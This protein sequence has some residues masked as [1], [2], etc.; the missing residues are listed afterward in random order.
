MACAQIDVDVDFRALE[1]SQRLV[2]VEGHCKALPTY[3]NA[4]DVYTDRTLIELGAR[5]PERGGN[6]APIGV[7]AVDRRFHERRIRHRSRSPV[8]I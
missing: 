5:P 6:P 1:S 2:L 7:V 8:G 3:R 4:H